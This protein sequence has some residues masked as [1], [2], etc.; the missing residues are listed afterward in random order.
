MTYTILKSDQKTVHEDLSLIDSQPDS[1]KILRIA[2][3]DT[4]VAGVYDQFYI[5]VCD[6]CL[7]TSPINYIFGPFTLE[8]YDPFDPI[9][10]LPFSPFMTDNPENVTFE[11]NRSTDLNEF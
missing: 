11:I 1:R 3:R 4:G 2:T 5:Q 7:I 6:D 10:E 9:N 8:I